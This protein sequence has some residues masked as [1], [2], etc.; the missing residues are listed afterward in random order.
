MWKQYNINGKIVLGSLNSNDVSEQL[1]LNSYHNGARVSDWTGL[2][3]WAK[4]S[5]DFRTYWY[6]QPVMIISGATVSILGPI[7]SGHALRVYG[8]IEASAYYYD[9]DQRLKTDI[10]SITDPLNK[11]LSLNGYMFTWKKTGK[12]DMGVIAQEVEKIFPEVVST[13]TEW[14]KSVEYGNLV[15]P[16]IEAV[17]ELNA[18]V[19]QQAQEIEILKNMIK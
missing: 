13:N 16:L 4:S 3:I 19:D 5:I 12:K 7:D 9:S 14:Y 18:K 17:K 8:D 1:W 6:Y 15:A 11:I 2:S 10:T